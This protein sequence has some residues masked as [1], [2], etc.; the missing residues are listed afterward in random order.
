M[1]EIML[2]RFQ[3]ELDLM[4]SKLL[5]LCG[6]GTL[7]LTLNQTKEIIVSKLCLLWPKKI[8]NKQT[9]N[10]YSCMMY[11]LRMLNQE[12]LYLSSANVLS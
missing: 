11:K 8:F 6:F 1:Q 10:D 3:K 9:Q 2:S 12:H 4:T 7:C 5:Y